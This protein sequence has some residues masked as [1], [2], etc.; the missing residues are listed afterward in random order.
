MVQT[1]TLEFLSRYKLHGTTN[2]TIAEKEEKMHIL[3]GPKNTARPTS[4]LDSV[5]S[6]V[7][8]PTAKPLGVPV[9]SAKSGEDRREN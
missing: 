5:E 4:I 9:L 2:E 8:R 1:Q 7:V 6:T 3:I